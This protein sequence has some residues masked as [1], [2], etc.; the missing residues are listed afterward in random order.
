MVRK[1]ATPEARRL[2]RLASWAKYNRS[3][4]GSARYRKYEEANPERAT[5]WSTLMEIKARD[6]NGK[7]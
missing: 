6:R 7:M 2:A 4:K 1:Y 3:Q 5:R